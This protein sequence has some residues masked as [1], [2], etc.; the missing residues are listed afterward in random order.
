MSRQTLYEVLG[1]LNLC[2]DLLE[3]QESTF[4]SMIPYTTLFVTSTFQSRP[5]FQETISATQSLTH[6]RCVSSLSFRLSYRHL[7]SSVRRLEF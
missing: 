4:G 1:V 7:F 5:M 2:P 3:N 6:S